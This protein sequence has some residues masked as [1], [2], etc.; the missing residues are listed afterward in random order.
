MPAL[1]GIG[2]RSGDGA[3]YPERDTSP[4]CDTPPAPAPASAWA[5]PRNPA[6]VATAGAPLRLLYESVSEVEAR[7]RSAGDADHRG[8]SRSECR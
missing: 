4:D 2:F 8:L 1:A 3:E 5:A 6:E 7:D